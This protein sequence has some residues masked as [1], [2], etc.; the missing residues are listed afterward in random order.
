M[1][2]H[3]HGGA[4][5]SLLSLLLLL[6]VLVQVVYLASMYR[7]RV[8]LTHD[9]VY[10]LTDSTRRV[11][12][13]LE[14]RLLVE[15]YFSPDSS[16]TPALGEARKTLRNVL[17]E[18]VEHSQGRMVVQYL[19]PQSDTALE[20]KAKRLGIKSQTIGD[21]GVRSLQY[22]E[23]WQG[24]RL[25]YGGKRQKVI[26][27]LPFFG[28]PFD[29]ESQLTP[30]IKA[31]TV[32]VK[33]KVGVIAFDSPP[34]AQ[35]G[36]RQAPERPNGFRRLIQEPEIKDRYEF[37]SLDITA[38]Q[39]IPD[40]IETL[41]LIRPRD[42]TDRHKY[43]IDQFVMR[44]KQLVV[45]ADT[46]DYSIGQKRLLRSREMNFDAK[47][48]ELEFRAQLAHYGVQVA[49]HKLLLDAT[50]EAQDRFIFVFGGRAAN[51]E[52]Y[53]Y[54]FR[55]L[56]KDWALE[57]E[58]FAQRVDG[59]VDQELATRYKEVFLPGVDKVAA[60]GLVAPFFYW[61]CAVELAEKLPEGV[62]GDVLFR[63][64]PKSLLQGRQPDLNP[65]G[66]SGNPV[67]MQA[68]MNGFATG[69]RALFDSTPPQQ[70]GLMVKV[71]GT[72]PSFFQGQKIPKSK[73]QLAAEAEANAAAEAAKEKDPLAGDTV[74]DPAKKL[75]DDAETQ[76]PVLT[77]TAPPV[78]A[79]K[80]KD[81]AT[82]FAAAEGAQVVVIGDSDFIRDDLVSGT[83][84]QLGGPLSRLGPAFFLSMLDWLSQDEDLLALRVKDVVDRSIRLVDPDL[85][86]ELSPAK[87]A[88]T[89][90][91]KAFW[92]RAINVIGPPL[93][94]LLFGLIVLMKRGASKRAFLTRLERRP[95]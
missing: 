62:S 47:G 13:G 49:S 34:P 23:L 3:N 83:Y 20:E 29:Y 60:A 53:P 55:P 94:L 54:W 50:V 78:V 28:R 63:T 48:S 80:D 73:A 46:D 30:K 11:L 36:F 38:G 42:L 66:L 12:G 33:P 39:F 79:E 58:R 24:L 82:L 69:L 25:R 1:K 2:S 37:I 41:L 67:E 85:A 95:S 86:S 74:T 18:L 51:V 21:R 10:T 45:F 19:D 56:D 84:S 31:L 90:E 57:A 44:G 76:G 52:S 15:A 26:P 88:E 65:I 93:L 14:D 35:A 92:V 43:V 27:F 87:F 6:C 40:E 9:K 16:L 4:L 81:P 17:D 89:V 71:S 75:E 59:S 32:D 77:P 7:V 8:D 70:H 91:R 5:T 72:L 64:S 61:P 68:S 22:K